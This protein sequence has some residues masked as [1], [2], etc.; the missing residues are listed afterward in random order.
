MVELDQPASILG[1]VLAVTA[2]AYLAAAYL[3][4]DARRLERRPDGRVLPA[5]GDR[6]A[7]VAGVVALVGIFVLRADAR[8]VFDGLTSRA[9]PLVAPVG[10][11]R[12]RVAVAPGATGAP[13]ARLAAIGAVASIVWAWG[14]AQWPYILPTSLKV[15]AAAAPSATLATVL[16]VFGVAAV[17][18]VPSLALLYV[19]DQRS[20]LPEESVGAEP[21]AGGS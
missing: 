2:C 1:G 21:A 18:I 9:L 19:L 13:R 6:H 17:V 5:A 20:L 4:W 3:I 14:V 7:V 15:S 8:Y 16:V 12:H 10:G 11:V